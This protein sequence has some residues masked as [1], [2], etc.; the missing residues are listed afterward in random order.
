MRGVRF[1][2][3]FFIFDFFIFG[4]IR[5]GSIRS[6]AAER[7]SAPSPSQSE[8]PKLDITTTLGVIRIEIFPDK[9]PITTR[10]FLKYVDK[11]FYDGTIFHRVIKGFMIQGGGY[12]ESLYQNPTMR[13]KKTEKPIKNEATNGLLNETGTIAMARTQVIDSA[14][15]QFFINTNNNTALNHKGTGKSEY[16]YAVFGRVIDGMNVVKKIE[17]AI[18]KRLGPHQHIPATPII[19]Q[20]ITRIPEN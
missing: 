11:K 14:T 17:A 6:V 19:I 20:S 15:S 7:P 8:N 13:P 5:C 3:I 2:T 18:V 4:L 10:N 9:A 16:G 1:I 12:R